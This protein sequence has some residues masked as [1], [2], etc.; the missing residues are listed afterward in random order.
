MCGR[1][2]GLTISCVHMG[3]CACESECVAVSKGG[4]SVS[5]GPQD[6]PSLCRKH[7]RLPCWCPP[8]RPCLH[9]KLQLEKTTMMSIG[10]EPQPGHTVETP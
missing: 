6:S 7:K 1:D 4:L 8:F 5:P 10:R 2:G 3:V 9:P